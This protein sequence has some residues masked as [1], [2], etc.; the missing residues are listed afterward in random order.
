MLRQMSKS[1]GVIWPR[2]REPMKRTP[3]AIATVC[4]TVAA[5]IT[6]TGAFLMA[7]P[8]VL[9]LVAEALG[10]RRGRW[11][12]RMGAAFL[13]VTILQMELVILPEFVA[14]LRLHHRLGGIGPALLPLWIAS[15]LLIV[16]CD[17]AFMIDTVKTSRNRNLPERRAP[18]IGDWI[19]W[20]SA[21]LLS[22]YSF[23][24]V[25]FLVRAYNQGFDRRDIVLTASALIV[26]AVVFDIALMIDATRPRQAW[27]RSR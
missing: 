11:L 14:E 3:L 22:V 27:R 23:W 8:L 26:M 17:V 2:H 13:S 25:P 5:T 4:V 20:V 16:W 7:I 18:G 12:I 15:I 9:G 21:L 10:A 24:G 19:V 1:L 6:T